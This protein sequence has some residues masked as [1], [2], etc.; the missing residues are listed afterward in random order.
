[1][2]RTHDLTE[3][4]RRVVTEAFD[5]TRSGQESSGHI[6]E[7][8]NGTSDQRY[9]TSSGRRRD[10]EIRASIQD[11]HNLQ[12]SG[13][14]STRSG[15]GSSGYIAERDVPSEQELS[16][17][18]SRGRE[19]RAGRLS[20]L[21]GGSTARTQGYSVQHCGVVDLQDSSR[22][23]NVV[24]DLR[25]L[26]P[27]HS[28]NVKG[29]TCQNPGKPDLPSTASENIMSLLTEN[30]SKARNV[31]SS[32]PSSLPLTPLKSSIESSPSLKGKHKFY[33]SEVSAVN[34]LTITSPLTALENPSSYSLNRQ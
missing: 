34:Y 15:Q 4:S 31:L 12:G 29:Y 18:Q 26:K 5:R 30:F 28:G 16:F 13:K 33:L 11:H 22:R 21:S 20:R 19:N 24:E 7:K 17:N 1:M 27:R 32:P 10:G 8:D 25:T 3:T 6:P 2:T 14:Y 23:K 9:N